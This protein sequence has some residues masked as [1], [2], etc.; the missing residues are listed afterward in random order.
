M[1]KDSG[2]VAVIR[3]TQTPQDHKD[4][5]HHNV[6]QFIGQFEDITP[7]EAIRS[8][9]DKEEPTILSRDLFC[10]YNINNTHFVLDKENVFTALKETCKV[11]KIYQMSYSICKVGGNLRRTW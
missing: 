5:Q 2:K 3:D 9:K 11:Y 1:L 8:M 10:N 7:S 4:N 6:P